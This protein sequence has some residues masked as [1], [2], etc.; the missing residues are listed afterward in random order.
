MLSKLIEPYVKP[1]DF[2]S[3]T[4]EK[5]GSWRN[6]FVAVCVLIAVPFLRLGAGNLLGMLP[7]RFFDAYTLVFA[8]SMWKSPLILVQQQVIL[9]PVYVIGL[10]LYAGV[11]HSLLWLAQGANA[12]FGA[13]LRC[14][15][16]AVP[17][18]LLTI[19]PFSGLSA[20]VLYA[21]IFL[22]YS[23]KA[24]HRTRWSRVLPVVA[25]NFSLLVWGCRLLFP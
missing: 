23:L 6:I 4:M 11:L 5:K 18:M 3:S 22:A 20:A 1:S 25:L 9:I 2:F 7:E 14:L 13:T 21:S 17:C 19:F 15:C 10:F 8:F 12:S 16:Y 24:T